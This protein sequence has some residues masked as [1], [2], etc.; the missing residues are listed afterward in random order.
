MTTSESVPHHDSAEQSEI[1]ALHE[2]LARHREGMAQALQPEAGPFRDSTVRQ[3][4]FLALFAW[5]DLFERP[6]RSDRFIRNLR[7]RLRAILRPMLTIATLF[8][9]MLLLVFFNG[10]RHGTTAH[11]ESTIVDPAI[12]GIRVEYFGQGMIPLEMVKSIRKTVLHRDAAGKIDVAFDGH[13]EGV[14][15]FAAKGKGGAISPGAWG[16]HPMGLKFLKAGTSEATPQ[17]K[18]IAFGVSTLVEDP[19]LAGEKP[20]H[21]HLFRDNNEDGV[22]VARPFLERLGYKDLSQLPKDGKVS[23]LYGRSD[24]PVRIKLIGVSDNIDKDFLVTEGFHYR[25]HHGE[26][27]PEEAVGRFTFTG[28]TDAAAAGKFKDFVT[29]QWDTGEDGK[30]RLGDVEKAGEYYSFD[31]NTRFGTLE[32]SFIREGFVPFLLEEWDGDSKPRLAFPPRDLTPYHPGQLKYIYLNVYPKQV[33]MKRAVMHQVRNALKEKFQLQMDFSS[34]NKLLMIGEINQALTWIG[35]ILGVAL[36]GFTLLIILLTFQEA[37]TRKSKK[38]GVQK[39]I[40]LSNRKVL[41]VYLFQALY[42]WVFALLMLGGTVAAAAAMELPKRVAEHFQMVEIQNFF[43]LSTHDVVV[44]LVATLVL[45][46]VSTLMAVWKLA[47]QS[48]ADLLI[49]TE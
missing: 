13:G 33:L 39:A 41:A 26:F 1:R 15:G 10:I 14:F 38:L 4:L 35:Q 37:I 8:L 44:I 47:V 18:V 19:M 6:Q 42:T 24:I 29:Q 48:P 45:A 3:V 46:V 28:F 17:N 5:T 11:L 23:V 9:L 25:W 7:L 16:H 20:I 43:L 32:R 34:I 27:D 12:N 31:V 2:H 36:A 49:D 21:G 40:G 30:Y 22:Y